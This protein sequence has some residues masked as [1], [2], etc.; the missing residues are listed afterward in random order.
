MQVSVQGG[1]RPDPHEYREV[2]LSIM[3]FL[4]CLI[5]SGNMAQLGFAGL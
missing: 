2:C 3:V 4:V 1:K 5:D